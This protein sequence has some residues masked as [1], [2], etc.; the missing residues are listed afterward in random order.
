MKE[1]SI[2]ESVLAMI[3][4]TIELPSEELSLEGNAKALNT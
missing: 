4:V 1:G 3:P 2:T